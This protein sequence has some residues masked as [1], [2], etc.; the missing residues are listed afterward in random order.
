MTA[1]LLILLAAAPARKLTTLERVQVANLERVRADRQ[2]LAMERRRIPPPEGFRDVRAILHCHAEDAAH[3]AG[4]R[5]ELLAAAKK[6]GVSAVLLSDH[7]RPERD[8]INDNWRGLRDGVLFIPGSEAEG[9]LNYPMRSI[10]GL[11][12]SSRDEYISLIRRDGGLIFLSHVEERL[13]HPM[14]RLDGLEIY[15]RHTDANDET[16][17]RQWFRKALSDPA[18]WADISGKLERYHE[19]YFG[20][21]QDYLAPI[22]AAWDRATQTHPLTGIAAN[23]AHHNQVFT[24]TKRDGRTAVIDSFERKNLGTV[25]LP[26]A[27]RDRPDGEVLY[28]LDFDPYEVS[29]RNVSTHL[30]VKSLTEPEVREALRAGRAYV[31]HDWLCDPTGFRFETAAGNR[32]TAASPV[33]AHFRLLR[34]GEPVLEQFTDSLDW[35]IPSPGVYRL[36]LW[37]DVGGE[38][39]PWIYSN[40]TYA[41]QQR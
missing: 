22:L 10:H 33:R 40:P 1:L 41:T 25:E 9:F 37:L 5:P 32:L 15:N 18:A 14:D 39:R 11:Q 17:Y 19:E 23:D 31:A 20:A 6:T 13:D 16:E 26:E 2:R 12:W 34:D 3:T 4:T 24:L 8:Y 27:L 21:Q 38:R 30:W 29:F 36:E 7:V 28:R 35:K